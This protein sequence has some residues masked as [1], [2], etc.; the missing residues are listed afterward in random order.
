[1]TSDRDIGRPNLGTGSLLVAGFAGEF[2][3]VLLFLPLLQTYLTQ[4]RHFGPAVAGYLLATYGFAR[5]VLQLPLGG[6]ADKL[7]QRFA[8]A[9]GYLVVFLAALL[10]WAPVAPVVLLPAAALYG[11]GHALADPLIPAVL[12]GATPA[13]EH[14]RLLAY[15]SLAQVGGLIA[16]LGCG[17]FVAELAG[18]GI[19]F[20]L[21]AAA[22]LLAAILLVLGVQVLRHEGTASAR[23]PLAAGSHARAALLDERVLYLFGVFFVLA[24]SL[25]LLTPDLTPFIDQRLHSSLHVMVTYLVPAALA[26]LAALPLGGLLADRYGRLPPLLAGAGISALA[27]G[28]LA[29]TSVPWQAAGAAVFVA[30]GLALTLPSSSAA[31]LDEAAPE[32][33]GLLLGGMMAVQ[34][35]A[36]AA[37][38]F[39]GG[40]MIAIGGAVVPMVVSAVSAWLAIPL[41][42][43]YASSPRAGRPGVVVGYTPFTRFLSRA[44]LRAHAWH[45]QRD[46]RLVDAIERELEHK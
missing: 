21:V 46:A 23:R 41:G 17:A 31:L 8:F 34:G 45:L 43:L 9:L 3:F 5:L 25:N 11:A 16:G 12:A 39:F 28:V 44:S 1:V 35:L 22:N 37:G 36:E 15:L 4:A 32:H 24:L 18:S 33:R 26:G 27:L 38:P 6:L 10:L 29:H 30:A 14:G 2:A 40:L 7:D 20:S 42:V 19:G 13:G